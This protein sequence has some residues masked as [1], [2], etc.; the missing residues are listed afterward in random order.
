MTLSIVKRKFPKQESKVLPDKESDR[1]NSKETMLGNTTNVPDAFIFCP[2]IKYG[3]N[4]NGFLSS[5]ERC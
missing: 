1:E 2:N 4:T 3:Y 5:L